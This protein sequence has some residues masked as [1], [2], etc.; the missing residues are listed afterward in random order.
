MNEHNKNK[1]E[2]PEK[3]KEYTHTQRS[4]NE[5]E[6]TQSNQQ[7]NESAQANT[8]HP[9]SSPVNAQSG[10]G[11]TTHIDNSDN[12]K[13]L[14][15]FRDLASDLLQRLNEAQEKRI[16]DA[17]LVAE[18]K[19]KLKVVEEQAA[20]VKEQQQEQTASKKGKGK[21]RS[22]KIAG[23]VATSAVM[24][25][26]ALV[27]VVLES[28]KKNNE[29]L[30]H[31]A[32]IQKNENSSKG[33]NK[34]SNQLNRVGIETNGGGEKKIQN[35]SQ[36]L[37]TTAKSGEKKIQPFAALRMDKQKFQPKESFVDT[38]RR[39]ERERK[40][41]G[42]NEVNPVLEGLLVQRSIASVEGV[43]APKVGQVF[44]TGDKIEVGVDF[45]VLG[46]Q[47]PVNILVR[48]TNVFAKPVFR[49]QLS[50]GG[51]SRVVLPELGR[52]VWYIEVERDRE[53]L[54]M[55]KIIVK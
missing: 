16:Q 48:S 43:N 53:T 51:V 36:R 8:N 37:R 40:E 12:S 3:P 23:L 45:G 27:V 2:K 6:G 41:F 38:M 18:I 54:G 7:S 49:V 52:G 29:R 55:G 21:G 26:G 1:P 25:G 46:G 34:K 24:V 28:G 50:G 35:N 11:S 30:H 15:Y 33:K 32:A 17:G 14:E 9:G 44:R 13:G 4:A 39:L 22:L 31:V 47:L 19:A 5:G 20:R 10:D 42:G